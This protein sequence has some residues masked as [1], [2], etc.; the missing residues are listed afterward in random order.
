LSA[1]LGEALRRGMRTELETEVVT[2]LEYPGLLIFDERG[3]LSSANEYAS[4]WLDE[5]PPEDRIPTELGL[6]LPFWL[7]ITAVRAH[8]SLVAGGDGTARTRVRSRRG[9]WL[10]GYASCTSDGGGVPAGTAVVLEPASPALI[11][12]LI[13]EAYGLTDRE[14]QVTRHIVRGASTDE[15]AGALYLSPHTV[16]DHIKAILTKVGVSS[17]GE[18]VA[19]LY[20]DHYEPL[21][22]AAA[23]HSVD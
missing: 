17:R 4:T 10:V 22:L 6:D 7:I 3:R 16:R 2:P 20:A 19:T 14:Q 1:P 23:R 13:V 5:L 21:H 9:Q 15:I 18:L 11:A 8:D 12:P